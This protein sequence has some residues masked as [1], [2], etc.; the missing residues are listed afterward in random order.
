[1]SV[2]A[3]P[4]QH[5][6]VPERSATSSSQRSHDHHSGDQQHKEQRDLPPAE[7]PTMS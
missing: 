4:T 5:R 1:M 6:G 2:H 3:A 7:V